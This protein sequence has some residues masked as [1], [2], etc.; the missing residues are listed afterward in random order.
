[1]DSL[2]ETAGYRTRTFSEVF[3]D[4]AT[5]EEKI[6]DVLTIP[7]LAAETHALAPTP[8]TIFV[9]LMAEYKNSHVASEDE[10]RFVLKCAALMYQFAPQFQ[11]E[12][13]AQ[14]TLRG[15]SDEDLRSGVEMIANDAAHPG[16]HLDVDDHE[17]VTTIN[18]QRTS[19]EHKDMTRAYAELFALLDSD[20]PS[21][22]IDRFR[23]LFL[24]SVAPLAPQLYPD[25][26]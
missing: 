13:E 8:E 7:Y 3:P 9:L 1:M 15:L 11:K 20:I 5:W 22:F 14:A 4:F 26:D 16:T 12:M 24:V 2:I 17:R 19:W 18:G 23:R 21:R 25:I 10:G 6:G